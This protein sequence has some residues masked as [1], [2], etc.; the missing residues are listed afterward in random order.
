MLPFLPSG[1]P[2]LGTAS[3]PA[4]KSEGVARTFGLA[5]QSVLSPS[6]SQL[7]KQQHPL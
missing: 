3:G 7:P 4:G 2:T 6:S 5:Q 1:P